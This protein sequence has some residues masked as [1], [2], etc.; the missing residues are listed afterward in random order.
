MFKKI[1]INIP[2]SKALTQMPYY[3][4]FMKD[5]LS[6]KGKFSKEGVVNLI[7]TYSVVIP[8]TLPMKMHDPGNCTIPCTIGNSKMGKSLR[9]SGSRINLM[10][11]SVVKRLCLRELTPIAMTLRMADK[12]LAQP[13]GILEDVLIKVGKFIFL[14][15]FVVIVIKEDKKV[16]LLLGRPFLGTGAA[17]IDLKKGELILMDGDETIHFNLNQSLK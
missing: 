9:D 6:R 17:L 1:E 4:K 13:K 3:A 15:D 5:I 2:Y 7:E 12:K 8:R 14:V 10:P 16:P 11:L